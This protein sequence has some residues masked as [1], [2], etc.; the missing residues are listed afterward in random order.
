ME[1][2]PSFVKSQRRR[3]WFFWGL[4]ATYIL[5]WILVGQFPMLALIAFL[6]CVPLAFGTVTAADPTFKHRQRN[7]VMWTLVAF[8]PGALFMTLFKYQHLAE[9]RRFSSY[10]SQHQCQSK[11]TVVTGTTPGGCDRY[12]NCEEP[13]E[14]EEVEFFC[15][16]TKR[17][18]TFSQFKAGQ[19][20]W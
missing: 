3:K 14:I 18:I 5:G 2:F 10:L 11:G 4:Y 19:Y 1:T 16:T 7:E 8:L 17:R 9:T 13:R 6:L 12:G 15:A 20:G